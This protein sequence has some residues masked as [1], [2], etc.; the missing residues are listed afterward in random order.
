VKATKDYFSAGPSHDSFTLHSNH[1]QVIEPS[2]Y[3]FTTMG[4]LRQRANKYLVNSS[5]NFI[6]R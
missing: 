5:V 1:L 3:P 4:L 6:G 2:R